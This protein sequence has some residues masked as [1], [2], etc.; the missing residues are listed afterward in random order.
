ME[1]ACYLD[2]AALVAYDMPPGWRMVLDERMGISG[3]APT[4]DARYYRREISPVAATDAAG[5]DVLAMLREADQVAAPVAARDT[6]FIGRTTEQAIILAFGEPLD[7]KAATGEPMLIADGWVEYPYSQTMFAAWQAKADYRAPTLEARG[8]DGHWHVV[9]EQFGYP[10]G[11]PRRMSV[12]IPRDKLPPGT[13]QLRLR[14]NQEIY[15]DRLSIAWAEP[16]PQVKR[17]PL[18]LASAAVGFCGFPRRTTHPQQ[19][20]DYDYSRRAPLWDTRHQSGWYTTFGPAEELVTSADDAMAVLGP[21]EEV[22][23]EFS[24]AGE[25]AEPPPQGWTRRFVLETVGWCKDMDLYTKTG[26]TIDP[27]PARGQMTGAQR[28][29][30]EALHRK[31]NTRYQSGG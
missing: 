10:A 17:K 18:H 28:T 7:S 15:W 14:T 13:T 19:R 22:H 31:Y 24:A 2:A 27:M 11:M 21:G 20:P 6:R 25:V 8:A 12:P 9:L 30:R 16:C 1:E 23:L 26:E 5:R 4:G 29:H 3:A